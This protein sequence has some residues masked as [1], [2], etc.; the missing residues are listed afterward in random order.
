MTTLLTAALLLGT[1][2]LGAVLLWRMPASRSFVPVPLAAGWRKFQPAKPPKGAGAAGRTPPRAPEVIE[3]PSLGSRADDALGIVIFPG[4]PGVPQLYCNFGKCLQTSFQEAGCRDVAVYVL[5]YSNFITEAVP[6]GE[7]AA[8]EAE[9]ELLTPVLEEIA[10]KHKGSGL[11]LFGHSIGAWCTLQHVTSGTFQSTRI[12]LVVLATPYLEFDTS[13]FGM[14]QIFRVVLGT[15]VGPPLV[16]LIARAITWVPKTL[17]ALLAPSL[18]EVERGSY[19]YEVILGTFAASP[20]HFEGMALMGKTEFHRLHPER[21]SALVSLPRLL[22]EAGRPDMMTI[23]ADDDKWFPKEHAERLEEI[24]LE[25]AKS[26]NGKRAEVVRLGAAP[27]AFVLSD[28]D[29]EQVAQ[30]VARGFIAGRR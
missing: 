8:I 6:E 16:R 26:G 7:V 4:N 5:G 30:H 19:N 28:K 13:T 20:H 17:Q 21:D 15:P 24:F 14:Q 9:T 3:L 18:A 1:A 29:C 25:A 22:A 23:Y 11:L 10:L 12:P 2:A 27:H